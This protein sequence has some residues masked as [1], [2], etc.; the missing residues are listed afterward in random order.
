MC[1]SKGIT[2]E[3]VDFGT[4][5]PCDHRHELLWN[6]G[7]AS[8]VRKAIMNC[9]CNPEG[10]NPFCIHFAYKNEDRFTVTDYLRSI[11]CSDALI[12]TF[13]TTQI[14]TSILDTTRRVAVK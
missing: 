13:Q 7:G 5:L 11:G 2:L 12:H 14:I 6:E 1:L 3:S 4:S 10:T 9:P 8:A